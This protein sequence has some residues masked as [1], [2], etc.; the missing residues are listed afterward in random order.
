M[1][2]SPGRDGEG[3]SDQDEVMV[4]QRA[5][6]EEERGG[7]EAPQPEREEQPRAAAA[8]GPDEESGGDE[9]EVNEPAAQEDFGQPIG[10]RVDAGDALARLPVEAN[11]VVPDRSQAPRVDDD[12]REYDAEP[13]GEPAERK[14]PADAEADEKADRGHERR[15]GE[16]L[17]RDR[18]GQDHA[19][20][21]GEQHDLA[22]ERPGEER[23]PDESQRNRGR[24][25][26]NPDRLGCVRGRGEQ[27]GPR[28]EP[29]R[30]A[31]ERPA[32]P[33][34]SG[35]ADDRQAEE[36]RANLVERVAGQEH[37]EP[38][39]QVEARRLRGEDV[40]SERLATCQSLLARQ[41]D[42]LVVARPELERARAEQRRGCE[43]PDQPARFERGRCSRHGSAA[44][45]GLSAITSPPSASFCQFVATPTR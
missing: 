44:S 24:V 20:E 22:A 14:P 31:G 27:D 2:R 11:H 35:D 26:G 5:V 25:R 18:R 8:E 38:Q 43:E 1:Q 30:R 34:G 41:V 45:G 36:D 10:V 3:R 23:E 39:E 42:A 13:S 6:P 16:E 17:H 33:P 32:Q 7:G 37:H 9:P 19:G 28:E 15:R 29:T 4:D 12:E 40:L 21:D